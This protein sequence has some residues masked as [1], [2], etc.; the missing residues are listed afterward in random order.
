MEGYGYCCKL[1]STA[2]EC[3]DSKPCSAFSKGSA[4]KMPERATFMT[5]YPGL[6]KN[7]TMLCGSELTLESPTQTKQSL[8]VSIP[9]T[10]YSCEY[11][12]KVPELTYL[13]TG[14][15]QV[16]FE[17]TDWVRAYIFSGNSRSNLTTLIE[18]S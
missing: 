9:S 3:Q 6:Q 8:N 13:R 1:N 2:A 7:H 12:I 4:M 10:S 18:D 14:K 16:W 5:F 17:R 15:L 11:R